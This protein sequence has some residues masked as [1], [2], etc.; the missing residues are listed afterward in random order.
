MRRASTA[1]VAE[2]YFTATDFDNS[3]I[4][5]GSQ[6][7]V[8]NFLKLLGCRN[9]SECLEGRY[10]VFTGLHIV[11]FVVDSDSHFGGARF[12]RCVFALYEAFRFTLEFVELAFIFANLLL[13]LL[14]LLFD[15]FVFHVFVLSA[16]SAAVN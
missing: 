5:E 6:N 13:N 9:C 16:D 4:G 1:G 8:N 11:A 15:L 14:Y 10:Y 3:I 12:G 2:K 7:S